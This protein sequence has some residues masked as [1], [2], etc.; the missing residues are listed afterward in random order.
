MVQGVRNVSQAYTFR[1][2][3]LLRHYSRGNF[4][5]PFPLRSLRRLMP[6]GV[7]GVPQSLSAQGIVPTMDIPR[8]AL[9]SRRASLTLGRPLLPPGPR[10]RHLLPPPLI[11]VILEMRPFA[12]VCPPG[13]LVILW[14]LYLPL[15]GITKPFPSKGIGIR[16]DWVPLWAHFSRRQDPDLRVMAS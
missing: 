7:F 14:P 1:S 8:A 3:S 16:C 12:E 10:L 6:H 5:H 4:T 11:V 13:L 15:R 9:A 2:F